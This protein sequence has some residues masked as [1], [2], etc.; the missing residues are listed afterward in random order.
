MGATMS[1]SSSEM[2]LSASWQRSNSALVQGVEPSSPISALWSR[3]PWRSALRRSVEMPRRR[4]DVLKPSRVRGVGGGEDEV[5]LDMSLLTDAAAA[6][7]L[8]AGSDGV[9]RR[10]SAVGVRQRST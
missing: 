8:A 4:K 9:V 10:R 7:A 1:C 6:G 3:R 5:F 2:S